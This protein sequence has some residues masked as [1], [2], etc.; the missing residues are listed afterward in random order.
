MLNYF[1]TPELPD[2]LK[3]DRLIQGSQHFYPPFSPLRIWSD[4]FS[5]FSS[6][7]AL[8]MQEEA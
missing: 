4:D 5:L 1:D 2:D 8:D 6:R 3:N 7:E